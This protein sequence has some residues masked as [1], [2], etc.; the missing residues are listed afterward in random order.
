MKDWLNRF[1]RGKTVVRQAEVQTPLRLVLRTA[2]GAV[3]VKGVEGTTATV[4]AEVHGDD[5]GRLGD[6]VADGIVFEDDWL[7]IESPSKREGLNVHYEVTVPFGTLGHISVVNGPVEVHGINGPIEINL[8]NG[9]LSI[10]NIGGALEVD[11]SNG[12][13]HIKSCRGAL[14]ANVSNGPIAI[15]HVAGPVNVTVSNGPVAIEDAS[16]S[17][18]ATATNG[19]VSY[20]GAVGGNIKMR[21]TRGGIVLELPGDSRFELDAEADRGNVHC[22]FDVKDAA[23]PST[24]PLPRVFLRSERGEIV[25]RESSPVGVS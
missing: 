5:G 6:M 7:S 11:L 2:H 1:G 10:E 14:E 13:A 21:S 17:I 3:S 20:R 12:P 22:E 9:P 8:S 25:V 19:P 18:D 23:A 4:R 15:E 24:A 16:S